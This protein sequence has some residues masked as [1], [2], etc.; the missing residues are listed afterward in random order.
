MAKWLLWGLDNTGWCMDDKT[1]ELICSVD[2]LLEAWKVVKEKGSSGGIDHVSVSEFETGI[3]ENI[4]QLHL[5]L[6]GN[7]YQPEPYKH[8]EIKKNET[9]TRPIGLLTVKDKIVQTAVKLV[10][11]PEID[12]GFF[13]CSY[14][15]RKSKNTV[16]AI[17]KVKN[18]IRNEQKSWFAICDIDNF[19]DSISHTILLKKLAIKINSPATLELIRCWLKMGY[20][21]EA[22]AWIQRDVGVPQGAI[23]SPLLS[24]FYLHPFDGL[25]IK[26]NIGYVRYADDF[27]MLAN[28]KADA[29]KA[30]DTA[31][32]FLTEKLLLT[33]NDNPRVVNV[34]EGFDFLGITFKGNQLAVSDSRKVG[35]LASI[36]KSC[37]VHH[38]G[39]INTEFF[40]VILNI[41]NYYGKIL[42]QPILEEIDEQYLGI[43][44]QKLSVALHQKFVPS[45]KA[46]L[47][48]LIEV[49]FFSH[50]F[51]ENRFEVYKSIVSH[52]FNPA[53]PPVAALQVAEIRQDTENGKAKIAET[54][55][56]EKASV[57]APDNAFRPPEPAGKPPLQELVKNS[58][59]A[60]TQP[61]IKKPMPA[62]DAD[63]KV[64]RKR[65]EY[66]KLESA[67]MELVISN[68]GIF[69]GISQN[70]IVLKK[71]GRIIHSVQQRNLKNI[72][73]LCDGI[74]LSSNLIRFCAENAIAI[75]FLNHNGTPYA[76]FIA[77]SFVKAKT[78][79][80]QLDSLGNSIAFI[81][82]KASILGKMKNQMNLLK[83]YYKYRKNIDP[84]FKQQF[85][86]KIDAMA[87]LQ[88]QLL[89]NQT[90]D[91]ELY[92]Q[93]VFAIEGQT[94]AIYWSL[95]K[96]L[97]ADDVVFPG[98]LHQEADDIV[99][100]L[101]N[102]GY[103]ILYS[104]VWQ[105]LLSAGLNPYI[106]YLHSSERN[107]P[108]LVFDFIEEFRQQA[109]DRAVIAMITK[110]EEYALKDGQLSFK[111]RKRLAEKVLERL[112]N[113]ETFR[114]E[115]CRLSDILQLQAHHLCNLITGKAKT[116]KPYIAKW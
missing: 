115:P 27:M 74:A 59:E 82:I 109:V 15:Y 54:T 66:Q 3:I 79:I 10:I 56:N 51:S 48:I 108:G 62:N 81:F 38:N 53:P 112:N 14:A 105:A 28:K 12:K 96:T 4:T 36:E 97:L 61:E 72:T 5:Q 29:Q 63:A 58:A 85:D 7:Q 50:R 98:R 114:G 83:Y 16:M 24:N 9:E 43:L 33:L 32:W 19:F 116:Y 91:I 26:H 52:V 47:D 31:K 49:R 64:A 17:H 113:P 13:H 6:L 76:Q 40:T 94:A 60:A 102:Y 18:L 86:G 99:N 93:Q 111:T 2:N 73:L 35:L 41:K 101:L 30:L 69:A 78:G 22:G 57:V 87:K 90:T 25:M 37:N 100:M 45:K 23:L 55:I 107:Q 92:R 103:G 44:K 46:M 11:E 20:I 67:G 21:D 89:T 106:S 34:S 1:F 71:D 77:P 68:P 65:R 70:R 8:I 110:G 39:K 104:R 95:I 75:H 88:S 80:A 42:P 84:D